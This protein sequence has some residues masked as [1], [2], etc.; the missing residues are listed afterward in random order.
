MRLA[1]MM[2]RRFGRRVGVPDLFRFRDIS[3]LGRWLDDDSG[4]DSEMVQS[5][6]R[7]ATARRAV[8][9]GRATSSG[10]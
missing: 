4:D 1:R 9:R 10:S 5:A 6:R 3:S 8:L 7:R 2:T